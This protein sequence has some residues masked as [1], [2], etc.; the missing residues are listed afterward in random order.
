MTRGMGDRDCTMPR[1]TMQSKLIPRALQVRCPPAEQQRVAAAHQRAAGDGPPCAPESAPIHR[2]GRTYSPARCHHAI[3]G[4]L[5][6]ET[7]DRTLRV[8][9]P[10]AL[11]DDRGTSQHQQAAQWTAVSAVQQEHLT[12]LNIRPTPQPP[13]RPHRPP[14]PERLEPSHAVRQHPGSSPP[15]KVTPVPRSQE[16]SPSPGT[17]RL[18]AAM[19][20]PTGALEGSS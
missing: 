12:D 6:A 13:N 3:L 14:R 4:Q 9:A 7:P 2:R 16:R 18:L 15:A 11:S 8:I 1:S 5:A 10:G 17:G 20:S 19:A